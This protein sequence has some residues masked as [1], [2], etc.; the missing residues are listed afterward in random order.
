[1][2][3]LHEP[4]ELAAQRGRP[5]HHGPLALLSGPERIESGWWDEADVERDYYVAR[6]PHGALLWIYRA[7]ASRRWFLHGFFG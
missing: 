4:T 6:D 2:W 7:C 3:L 1:L 5:R